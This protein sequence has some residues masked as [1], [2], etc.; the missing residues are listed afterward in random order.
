V[1]WMTAAGGILHKEFH[2]EAFTRN[3]RD[4]RDGFSSGSN[5]PA[6]DKNAEPGYQPYSTGTFRLW[7]C[8][9]ALGNLRV[10]AG[11]YEGRARSPRAASHRS[12][13]G[14]F[15]SIGVGVTSLTL[16]E[17]HTVMVVMLKRHRADQW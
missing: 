11:E 10:I 6:K 8:R 4:A 17:G 14:I 9:T 15:G 13:C 5:L 16:P 1:Q 12:T 3:G 2:S 7:P